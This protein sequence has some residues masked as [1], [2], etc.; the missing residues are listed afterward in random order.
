MVA[1]SEFL[2]D[3]EEKDAGLRQMPRDPYRIFICSRD[4]GFF[5]DISNGYASQPNT[6][7]LVKSGKTSFKAFR[8]A[9]SASFPIWY[10]QTFILANLNPSYISLA[11]SVIHLCS[12]SLFATKRGSRVRGSAAQ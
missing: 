8:E 3:C 9:A 11:L 5:S 7:S 6:R 2:T 10:D 12:A 4:L 1:D